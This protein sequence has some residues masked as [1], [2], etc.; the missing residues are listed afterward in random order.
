MVNNRWHTLAT[1]V[2]KPDSPASDQIEKE[3]GQE[4]CMLQRNIVVMQDCN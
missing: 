4:P 1:T 3:S 2:S